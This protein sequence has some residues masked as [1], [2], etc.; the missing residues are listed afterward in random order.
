MASGFTV[1]P[2]ALNE[3]AQGINNSLA[4]LDKLGFSETAGT[5]MGFTGLNLTVLQVGHS[6]LTSAFRGFTN[7]WQWGVRT[8]VQDGNQISQRLGLNAGAYYQADQKVM[9]SLKDLVDAAVGDPHMTDAQ[10]AAASWSQDAAEVTGAKTPEGNMTSAQAI[11]QIKAT[12]AAEGKDVLQNGWKSPIL[13]PGLAPVTSI[14]GVSNALPT[15]K[16]P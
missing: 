12:W 14:P 10:A 9:G 3:T 8:L 13:D 2:D 11:A 4:D 5:G 6:G 16:V 1:N 7:R 15:P